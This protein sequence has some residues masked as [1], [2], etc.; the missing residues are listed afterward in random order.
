MLRR[1]LGLIAALGCIDLAVA[2][3]PRQ[4]SRTDYGD[5]LRAMWLGECI[6]NWTG[7][8]TEGHRPGPPF[9]TD[10]DWGLDFLGAPLD[11]LLTFNPWWADDDTDVEYV[12]LHLLATQGGT[13]LSAQ[14][15]AGGWTQHINRFIWVSNASARGLIGRGV[16]PPMTGMGVANVNRLMIDAQ[17]TTEIFG[18]LCPGMPERALEVADLPIR[19]TAS[20]YAA[21]ASQFYVALYA[22]APMVPAELS[23]REKAIWLFERA[24]AYV[25]NTSKSADICDFV[26]AD[27]LSN[28][29]ANN[30]ERTR[31]LVYQRYQGNAFANGF[32]YRAWYESSVNFASGVAGLL[33]GECDFRKTVRICTCFGWDS[34]NATATLGG[35]IGIMKGYAGLTA[36]FP[37]TNFSDRFWILRTRD[38]LP[39]YLPGDAA[40][41][42]TFPMMSDRMLDIVEREIVAAGGLVDAERGVWLLPPA[43]GASTAWNPRQREDARSANNVMRR[44]GGT[45]AASSSVPLGSP[46]GRGEP[47]VATFANGVEGNNEGREEN[48]ANYGFYCSLGT[49][50]PPGSDVVL[51]VTYDRDVNVSAVRFIEGERYDDG[52]VQGGWYQNVAVEVLQGGAWNVVSA[53]A[54]AALDAAVPFQLIDYVLATPVTARGVR[55]RGMPGGANRFVTCAEVDALLVAGAAPI[56]RTWDANG[57]GVR[58]VEDL[59]AWEAARTDL[60]GDGVVDPRDRVYEEAAVRWREWNDMTVG[61]R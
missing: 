18:A 52:V 8:R 45:V 32:Q 34:D 16:L 14:Q 35:M 6:A 21:H 43:N 46:G 12:Y 39:D 37:G 23:G 3:T 27:F 31:D 44:L 9:L 59:Y 17:L 13:S 29:D 40:A 60:T 51:S 54:T 41:E 42:D 26:Y 53:T 56:A 10:A 33:Y 19:T 50:I 47:W 25:P 1:L 38:N 55:V 49:P 61:R 36:T 48:D 24:R 5:R 28:P 57:D 15:I 4:L 11:Y 20:G 30:W 58:S 7:L 22:L 2:Q